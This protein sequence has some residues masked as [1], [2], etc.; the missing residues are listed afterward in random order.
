MELSEA[1]NTPAIRP[2]R[3]AVGVLAALS[4]GLPAAA[5]SLVADA[6]ITRTL[7]TSGNQALFAIEVSG[8]TGPCANTVIYFPV[9]AAVDVD[10]HKRAYSAA[11][12]ALATGMKIS[13]WNYN[14]NSCAGAAYISVGD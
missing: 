14:D 7:N 9:S 5:G 12:L 3:L 11:L 4:F 13:V 6:T 10:T 1:M 2:A 8:G